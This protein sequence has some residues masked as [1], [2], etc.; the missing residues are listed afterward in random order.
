MCMYIYTY[1]YIYI[2]VY[3]CIHVYIC[4]LYIRIYIYINIYTYHVCLQN[5]CSRCQHMSGVFIIT[6]STENTTPP[7][8][9]KSRNPNSWVHIQ[10]KPKSQF[11]FVPRDAEKSEFLD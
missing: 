8:S 3:I 2:Y 10:I 7:K 5:A 4:I 11:E 9:T 6:E 1:I